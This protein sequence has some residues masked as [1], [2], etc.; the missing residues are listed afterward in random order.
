[1]NWSIQKKGPLF[2]SLFN[3]LMLIVVAF[4]GW[5]ILEERLH[6]GRYVN[7]SHDLYI[8]VLKLLA[9][10]LLFYKYW[11]L[12]SKYC[13]VNSIMKRELPINNI[14]FSKY[15]KKSKVSRRKLFSSSPHFMVIFHE[16]HKT[17]KFLDI[18][19]RK[20]MTLKQYF[21]R[22]VWGWSVDCCCCFAVLQ[23][24]LW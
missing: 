12:L 1:M 15:L 6:V 22:V 10:M 9:H 7:S 8:A 13:S 24:L 14:V 23:G 21:V 20:E 4:V 3:P 11:K 19:M 17:W 2:V 18:F 5:A 16:K